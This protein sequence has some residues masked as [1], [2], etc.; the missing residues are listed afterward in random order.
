M[1]LSAA[2]TTYHGASLIAQERYEERRVSSECAG[3][4][5]LSALPEERRTLSFCAFLPP[6]LEG[7]D[8]PR[9]AFRC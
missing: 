9:K 4:S 8:G 5:P 7:S 1:S 3:A 6:V 2:A